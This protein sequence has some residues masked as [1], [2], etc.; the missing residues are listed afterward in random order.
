MLMFGLNESIDQLAITNSVH[1]YGNVL[2]IEVGHILQKTL[3]LEAEGQMKKVTS[4]LF[5]EESMKVGLRREDALL[6]SKWIVCVNLI[7]TREK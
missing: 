6:R 7:A 3:E 5:D 1:W 4:K 2:R